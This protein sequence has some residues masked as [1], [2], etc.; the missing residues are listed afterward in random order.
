MSEDT[1]IL[2]E[3]ALAAA[4]AACGF[5]VLFNVPP[6][7]LWG[8]SMCGALAYACRFMLVEST[9]VPP[10]LATLVAA[11]LVSGVATLIGKSMRAPAVIF[12]V[13]GVIPLVPGALA[14]RTMAALFTLTDEGSAADPQVLVAVSVNGIRTALITLAIAFGVAVPS[15]LLRRKR[16]MT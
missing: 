6:R 5:A 10:V 15:L 8:A 2:F 3:N 13:P 4:V 1:P 12:V 9:L 16:P 11:T 7:A 14:F